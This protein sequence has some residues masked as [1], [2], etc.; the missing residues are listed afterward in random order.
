MNNT[1]TL[2]L[3]DPVAALIDE[4]AIADANAS[5]LADEAMARSIDGVYEAQTS[6]SPFLDSGAFVG[7]P[8]GG[9]D[10]TSGG[11]APAPEPSTLALVGLSAAGWCLARRRRARPASCRTRCGTRRRSSDSGP[12]PEAGPESPGRPG[13]AAGNA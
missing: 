10:G 11:G 3:F 6:I 12:A 1:L 2:Q 8:S 7:A 5:S 9:S 13:A 4:W